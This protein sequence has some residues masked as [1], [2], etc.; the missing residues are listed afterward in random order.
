MAPG[1]TGPRDQRMGM[2]RTL[3]EGVRDAA[4]MPK[5]LYTVWKLKNGAEVKKA[6]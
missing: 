4:C 6:E 1:D 5:N 2:K 3:V